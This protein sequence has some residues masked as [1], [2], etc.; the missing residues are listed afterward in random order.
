[1][2]VCMFMTVVPG[3]QISSG[4]VPSI[5]TWDNCGAKFQH[6]HQNWIS[7]ISI[8]SSSI[9]TGSGYHQ[10]IIL[11]PLALLDASQTWPTLCGVAKVELDGED[12]GGGQGRQDQDGERQHLAFYFCLLL[13][14]ADWAT[15]VFF[16]GTWAVSAPLISRDWPDSLFRLFCYQWS[17]VADYQWVGDSCVLSMYTANISSS[18]QW[19]PLTNDQHFFPISALWVV[20][21]THSRNLDIRVSEDFPISGARQQTISGSETDVCVCILSIYLPRVQDTRTSWAAWE[22]NFKIKVLKTSK[23]PQKLD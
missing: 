4:V 1:M 12:G 7:S 23:S 19:P 10:G 14:L 8:S 3:I 6:Q 20:G 15:V 11:V 17:A 16:I 18:G 5:S 21:V 22:D 13:L 9:S 2:R